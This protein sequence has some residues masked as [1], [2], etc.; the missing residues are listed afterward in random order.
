VKD[1]FHFRWPVY[2]GKYQWEDAFHTRPVAVADPEDEGRQV[3]EDYAVMARVL[4]YPSADA[5]AR[6]YLP[7]RKEPTL[8]ITFAETEPTEGGIIAFADRYG[9]LGLHT[10]GHL[11][12]PGSLDK[13]SSGEGNQDRRLWIERGQLVI[14]HPV[15]LFETWKTQIL[16]M[17][18]AVSLWQLIRRRNP[19]EIEEHIIWREDKMGTTR[20]FY[21]VDPSISAP[22]RG[23]SD[24]YIV[25]GMYS[26]AHNPM[27]L[28]QGDSL[29]PARLHVASSISQQLERQVWPY[30]D[31]SDDDAAPG[32]LMAP[33]SLIGA[34]WLQFAQGVA[35]NSEFRGCR[36]CGRLFEVSRRASRSDRQFCENGCRVQEYR[37]RR[38]QARQMF[39]QGKSISTITKALGCEP[40]SVQRWVKGVQREE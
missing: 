36:R 39:A 24:N 23:T 35:G 15:E 25:I 31:W 8:F 30:V 26:A 9:A 5:P 32:L 33:S 16:S 12:L 21:H 38:K 20:V 4:R 1:A 7:L 29:R 37:N 34:L 18:R 10:E 40:G 13:V 6:E 3:F 28:R 22:K 11:T 14:G 27:G 2:S 17:R 19:K